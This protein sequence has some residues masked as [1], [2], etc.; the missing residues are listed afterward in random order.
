MNRRQFAQIS[1]GLP[2][3]GGC[4]GPGQSGHSRLYLSTFQTEV[5]PPLGHPLMG[6]GIEP[7]HEIR[8]PLTARGFVLSGTGRPVVFL[9]VD[10]VSWDFVGDARLQME[11]ETPGVFQIYASGCSGNVT[12]GKYN[13]AAP[14]RRAELAGRMATAMREAWQKT[15]RTPLKHVEFKSLP[16]T[17]P[18]REDRQFSSEALTERLKS[19]KPFN[20]RGTSA[21]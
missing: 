16:F 9:S 21:K 6:G 20:H 13:D 18:L 12:A 10:L 2:F 8:T 1:L 5:T 14:E 15:E 3:L 11:R 17:L 7:A 4:L 19:P